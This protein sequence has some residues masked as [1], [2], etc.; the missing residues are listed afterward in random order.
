MALS[1]PPPFLLFQTNSTLNK[2]LVLNTHSHQLLVQTHESQLLSP[3]ELLHQLRISQLGNLVV[4]HRE[5]QRLQEPI[6]DGHHVSPRTTHKL[7]RQS[8]LPVP[9]RLVV[10]DEDG[11]SAHGHGHHDSI[12]HLVFRVIGDFVQQQERQSIR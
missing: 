9:S 4:P 7:A 6:H 11:L 3:L 10:L 12:D 8:L 5:R 1:S 2:R